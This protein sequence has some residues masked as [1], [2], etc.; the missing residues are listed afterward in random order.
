MKTYDDKP[1]SEIKWTQ[2]KIIVPTQ[3]D[4][5]EL[6]KAF[7]HFHYSDIDTNYVTVNQLA[8]EYLTPEISG[9]PETINN[10]IVDP[11]L[12]KKLQEPEFESKE[13]T[14]E[15][16]EEIF[17]NLESNGYVSPFEK[18]Q[19]F[20]DIKNFFEMNDSSKFYDKIFFQIDNRKKNFPYFN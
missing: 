3:E 4:K 16:F 14:L 17:T 6:E 18:E 12:F 5:E 13:L 19:T 2:Y 1:I 15:T 11:E 9:N 7:E 20:Q 8:H 10:I